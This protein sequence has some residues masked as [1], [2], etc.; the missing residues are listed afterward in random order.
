MAIPTQNPGAT[1]AMQAKLSAMRGG[2][3]VQ[4]AAPAQEAPP[5]GSPIDTAK[6]HLVEALKALN[7]MG[8]AQ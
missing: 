4:A 2:P 3:P 6:M 1:S 5:E 8:E 7:A